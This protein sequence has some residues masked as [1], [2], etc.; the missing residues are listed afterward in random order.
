MIYGP[1]KSIGVGGQA[2]LGVGHGPWVANQCCGAERG[3]S[4]A[5]GSL[6]GLQCPPVAGGDAPGGRLRVGAFHSPP[7]PRPS[8]PLGPVGRGSRRRP[9]RDCQGRVWALL[10]ALWSEYPEFPVLAGGRGQRLRN[11]EGSRQ[12]LKV[13]RPLLLPS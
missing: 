12:W 6:W 9:Q 1:W 2:F 4:T 10:A 7:A 13:Q 11:T 8:L 5:W 3:L